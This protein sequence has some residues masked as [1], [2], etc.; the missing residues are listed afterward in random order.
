MEKH[1]VLR[2]GSSVGWG[3]FKRSR[4]GATL[5]MWVQILAKVVGK[6]VE[7][8]KNILAVPSAAKIAEISARISK[9]SCVSPA[10][11]T[12]LEIHFERKRERERARARGREREKK[13]PDSVG[14]ES[15]TYWP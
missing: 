3:S 5:L 2:R 11:G 9:K 1:F 14:Y 13:G 10:K 7:N 15:T 12:R 4:V 6:I 8:K